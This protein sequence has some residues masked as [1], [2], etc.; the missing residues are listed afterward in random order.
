MLIPTIVPTDG[1]NPEALLA[2][3][4]VLVVLGLPPDAAAAGAKAPARA[5]WIAALIE[6]SVKPMRQTHHYVTFHFGFSRAG[7][8]P[9]CVV[10]WTGAGV[11]ALERRWVLQRLGATLLSQFNLRKLSVYLEAGS[12]PEQVAFA[13]DLLTR[14]MTPRYD[15]AKL[16]AM[17]LL[18]PEPA[19]LKDVDPYFAQ[20]L[21]RQLGFRAW[22]NENPDQLTSIEMGARLQTFCK[23]TGCAFETLGQGRLQELGMNLLLAVGQASE[24]S[25]SRLHLATHNVTPGSRPLLLVGKGITFDTGGINLKPHEGFVNC[26]KNDM[27]GAGLMAHLF[28]ALV[29]TGYPGPLALA[30]PC[31]ENLIG[32]RAMKPGAIIRSYAGKDVIVDHTDAEGRLILADALHYAQKQW[33]PALT[34]LAATLT[35]A[36]LRQ[37]TNFFTPV[38][39]ASEAFQAA[40]T[41]SGRAFGEEFTYWGAFLP[42]LMGNKSNAADLTNMGRM[43]SHASMGGGSNVAAHFLKEFAVAPLIHIDIFASTWNWSGDYP[44]AHYGATGAPFNSLFHALRAGAP[45]LWG[46]S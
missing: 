18:T 6:S 13:E 31:C 21:S 28:M 36:A 10:E 8:S 15:A 40:L 29:E 44:G 25:P 2:P 19:R 30:I 3:D 43:P 45:D 9:Y 11:N 22:V 38:H 7:A 23:A 46:Y 33:N 1:K 24:R 34:V 12:G 35:T 39:F 5:A 41:K 26:M 4:E 14:S 37:F 17:R 16:T 27:G 42:F 32:A 20:R